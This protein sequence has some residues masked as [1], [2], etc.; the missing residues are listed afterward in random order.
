[1]HDVPQGVT[2]LPGP[3]LDEALLVLAA[4]ARGPEFAAKLREP[5]P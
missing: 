3:A 4:A 2:T 1:V 5:A